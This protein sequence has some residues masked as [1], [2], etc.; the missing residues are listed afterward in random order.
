[1]HFGSFSFLPPPTLN[2][3]YV[4]KKLQKNSCRN[5]HQLYSRGL[6][7]A[8]RPVW[9]LQHVTIKKKMLAE[10]KL[11]SFQYLV[12]SQ[13]LLV[14]A[15][16]ALKSTGRVAQ[17]FNFY[18]FVFLPPRLW[19]LSLPS[20]CLCYFC[21]FFMCVCVCMCLVQYV[22]YFCLTVQTVI[23]MQELYPCSHKK[24]KI[25]KH[26]CPD[27]TGQCRSHQGDIFCFIFTFFSK[28]DSDPSKIYSMWNMPSSQNVYV[29]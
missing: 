1:M 3:I 13:L 28:D 27:L 14:K 15:D 16:V 24:S 19:M 29:P 2:N 4:L 9:E 6:Q 7:G 26:S 20:C 10:K 22:L 23:Y 21:V 5:M 12:F 11:P 17:C 8:C 25:S 18:G